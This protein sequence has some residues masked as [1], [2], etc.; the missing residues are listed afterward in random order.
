MP[1]T[2][3]QAAHVAKVCP[4]HRAEMANYLE[5]KVAVAIGP[6]NECGNDVPP[7]AIWVV[8]HPAFWIGCHNSIE[9]AKTTAQALGLPV[10]RVSGR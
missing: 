3:T 8:E 1:L 4:E 2:P 9:D 5:R 6:Q 10:V 7:I